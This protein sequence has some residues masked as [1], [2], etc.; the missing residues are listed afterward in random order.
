MEEGV[1]ISHPPT[2]GTKYL[3]AFHT[4][5]E[6]GKKYYLYLT[7]VVGKSDIDIFDYPTYVIYKTSI[8]N[9]GQFRHFSTIE[10]IDYEA[11]PFYPIDNNRIVDL[12]NEDFEK[13]LDE[14]LIGI[15][16]N[17]KGKW[18]SLDSVLST[19]YPELFI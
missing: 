7:P 12:D 3:L 6:D 9:P 17:Y 8:E 16:S 2:I 5:H 14:F 13:A 15:I 1:I 19:Q 18:K 11:V 4:T 10:E